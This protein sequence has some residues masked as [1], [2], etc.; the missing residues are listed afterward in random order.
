MLLQWKE[1]QKAENEI[2]H[3]VNKEFRDHVIKNVQ[4]FKKFPFPV[5]GVPEITGAPAVAT[6][7]AVTDDQGHTVV[8]FPVIAVV[9][10]LSFCCLNS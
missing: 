4:Y 9:K 10:L 2:N 8:D 5:P 1:Q 7:P 3:S 6:I